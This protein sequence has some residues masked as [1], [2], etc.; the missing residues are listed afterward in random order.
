LKGFFVTGT[1]TGC[2]KT[3]VSLGLMLALRLAGWR[4][5]GMKPVASGCVPFAPAAAVPEGP[6]L[7]VQVAKPKAR[8]GLAPVDNPPAPPGGGAPEGTLVDGPKLRNADAERLLA[9]SSREVP[10]DW[11]NPYAFLPPIAPHIAAQEAGV[12]IDPDLIRSRAQD[13]AGLGDLLIVEGLGGW[14]VPLGPDLAVSDLPALLGLPVILVVGLRLGCLN[15]ALLTVESILAGGC[16]LAGWVANQIEP[17][18][19]RREQNLAT[20]ST[21]LPAPLLGL[22]PWREAP[23]PAVAPYLDVAALIQMPQ[24]RLDGQ[25]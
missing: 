3:E 25:R 9:Q 20:L 16:R 23:G 1:D 22:I 11:V 19:A 13:L 10:Y 8:G 15:H 21:L 18:M 12:R 14:R 17:K 4:V 24:G 7:V 6:D 5:Q 2:G